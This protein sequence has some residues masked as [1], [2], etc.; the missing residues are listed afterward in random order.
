M[1]GVTPD[2]TQS[3]S[4]PSFAV[5]ATAIFLLA[6]Y[7]AMAVG[8]KRHES[9]TSDELVHLTAGVSYWQNRDFRLHPENGI[10]PQ[11]WAALPAL[12]GGAKFPALADNPYWRTS[13]AWHIGYQF[14]YETGE[15]HFPRLMAGRAMIALFGVATGCLV[16]CWSRR[17]FGNIGALVSLT[18]FAFCPTFL[19]HGAL[20]TS[21]M[22]MSFFFLAT[23]GTWWWHLHDERMWVWWLSALVLGLAFVA[24]YSAVLLLPMLVAMA[25]VRVIASEPLA[26]VGRVFVNRREKITAIALSTI[27]HGVV[28]VLIIWAF[29]GFRFSAFN[30]HLPSADRFIRPWSFVM[31]LTTPSGRLIHILLGWRALPESYLYGLAYVFKTIATRAAFLNGEYS[32]TGWPAFFPWA[33]LLKTTPSVL[34]ALPLTGWIGWRRWTD[35]AL[36]RQDIYRTTPLIV[37]FVIYWVSSLTSHLNIGHRHLMPTYPALF[38]AVGILGSWFVI[39]R[40]MQFVL[41]ATLLTSH[42]AA[43]VNIAPHYLA[44]FNALGGGPAQSWRHLVDSSLDWGQDLPTLKLWLTAHAGHERVYLAYF[45]TSEPDYYAIRAMRMPFLNLFNK[46]NPWYEVQGGIYCISATILQH[47][48]SPLRGEWRLAW[49]KE[50]QEGRAKE[51]L[52]REYWNNSIIRQELAQNGYAAAFESTWVRYDQLRFARFCHY[53]RMRGPDANAGHSILIYRLTDE[54]IANAIGGNLSTWTALLEKTA[55]AKP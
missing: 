11:Y 40:W 48:Y 12:F 24:K 47:V 51:S 16:F 26:L 23:V 50:Y 52:F 39:R 46:V 1:S 30:P 29:Y 4:R 54:E 32:L 35:G 42:V 49:E 18:F 43:S 8:S 20:V 34:L 22:C 15:D 5:L 7:F 2:F 3:T 17:L 38:I 53:L 14:F 55:A 37:L 19:A 33:F 27:A 36:R 21:D 6:L 25:A 9:T 28:V 45:G 44:Y 13:N 10:L 41:V 31:D